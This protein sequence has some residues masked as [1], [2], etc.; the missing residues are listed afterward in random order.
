MYFFFSSSFLNGTLNFISYFVF[1]FCVFCFFVFQGSKKMVW[2]ENSWNA[3]IN[4]IEFLL[5]WQAYEKN[6]LLKKKKERE[7]K[8]RNE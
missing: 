3:L 7:R 2:V 6:D 5:V 8:K 4:F 1:L